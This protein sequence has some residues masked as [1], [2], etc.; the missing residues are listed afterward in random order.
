MG[1]PPRPAGNEG[2]LP[3]DG[4]GSVT[5]MAAAGRQDE[6]LEAALADAVREGPAPVVSVYLFGSRAEGR[7][8][9]QSDV[10]VGILLPRDPPT[11]E[12][13]R[14]DLRVQITAW[15]IGRLRR[16][17]VDVVILNDVPPQSGR[18]IVTTG[19]RVLCDDAAADHALVRD[20]QLRAADLEPFL[21][22][23]RRVKLAA[24][25]R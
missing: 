17:D 15:L 3:A 12:R 14:F 13:E 1:Q 4:R 22:R 24:T 25:A 6:E 8:H 10:D 5:G 20:V 7:A 19:R 16:G 18:R 23:T 9:A 21:R 11:T 2:S